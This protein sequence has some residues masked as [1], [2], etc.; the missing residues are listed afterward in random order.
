MDK[1]QFL[2]DLRERLEGEVPASIIEKN[3][4]YYDRYISEH[5]V[6]C[7]EEIGDPMLIATTIIS[8]YE[9]SGDKGDRYEQY[10]EKEASTNDSVKEPKQ[11]I[12]LKYKLMGIGSAVALVCILVFLLRVFA[13]VAAKVLFPIAIVAMVVVLL[14]K[15]FQK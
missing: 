6:A 8:S 3:I 15:I 5:G 1:K 12:P 7:I 13:F 11:G 10:Y 4:R 9:M 2:N 14:N